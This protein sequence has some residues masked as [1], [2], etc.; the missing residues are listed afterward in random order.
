M[1]LRYNRGSAEVTFG[2]G[3][4]SL[5]VG[6]L[7]GFTGAH[8]CLISKWRGVPQAS[9]QGQT[10]RALLLG[11]ASVLHAYRAGQRVGFSKG[12]GLNLWQRYI[13]LNKHMMFQIMV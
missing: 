10:L 6:P 3:D 4:L 8:E 9:P 12:Y 5:S 7:G 1:L 11:G 2:R 13:S